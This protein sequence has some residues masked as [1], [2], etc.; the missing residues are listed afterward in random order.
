VG[1]TITEVR[2]VS[3]NRDALRTW[4]ADRPEIAEKMLRVLARRLRRTNNNLAGLNSTDVPGRVAKL[5]LELAQ[6]FGT[7]DDG[8]LRVA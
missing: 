6:C 1:P 2:A 8:A 3:I 4:I 7:R 5:L